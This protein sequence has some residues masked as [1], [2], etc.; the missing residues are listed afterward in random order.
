[1]KKSADLPPRLPN[2]LGNAHELR[3]LTPYGN[4]LSSSPALAIRAEAIVVGIR[5][6]QSNAILYGIRFI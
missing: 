6:I 2:D 1:M 3:E 5:L 4:D